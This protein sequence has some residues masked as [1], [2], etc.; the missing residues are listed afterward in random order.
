MSAFIRHIWSTSDYPRAD[1]TS[2]STCGMTSEHPRAEHAHLIEPSGLVPRPY[3]GQT[4]KYPIT[5][6]VMQGNTDSGHR[7][8][9]HDST[10]TKTEST[11]S[12]VSA[13]ACCNRLVQITPHTMYQHVWILYT[14]RPSI[15]RV[16]VALAD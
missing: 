10:H 3:N 12:R 6:L 11:N 9:H 5:H 4:G 1:R 15:S 13:I 14:S 8:Q 7:V 16:Q 2:E